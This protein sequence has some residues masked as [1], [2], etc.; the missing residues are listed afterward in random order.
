MYEAGVPADGFKMR[1]CVALPGSGTS[2]ASPAVYPTD[3]LATTAG[4]ADTA[5]SFF[6]YGAPPP[7]G[8]QFVP[9]SKLICSAIS[10]PPPEYVLSVV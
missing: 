6:E 9:P 2:H 10:D 7:P 8:T 5:L 4:F 1:T 3:A